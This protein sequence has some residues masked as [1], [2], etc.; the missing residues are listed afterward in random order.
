M[1]HGTAAIFLRSKISFFVQQCTKRC[2]AC[3]AV[4]F[5]VNM[6]FLCGDAYFSCLVALVGC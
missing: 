6:V 1:I 5:Q 4:D 3:K 2:S